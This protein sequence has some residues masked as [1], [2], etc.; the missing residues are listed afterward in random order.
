ME[1]FL[2]LTCVEIRA[3]CPLAFLKYMFLKHYV[4]LHTEFKGLHLCTYRPV[5]LL[6][7]HI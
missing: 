6:F 1:T 3:H 7:V 5:F 2:T 4:R